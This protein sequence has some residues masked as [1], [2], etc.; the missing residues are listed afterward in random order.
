MRILL[1]SVFAAFFLAAC[2][3]SSKKEE[4][5]AI[6]REIVKNDSIALETEKAKVELQKSVTKVDSLINEL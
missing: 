5:A 4:Q 1:L 6:E 2:A 3:S